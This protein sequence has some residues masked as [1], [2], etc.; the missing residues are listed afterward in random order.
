[1]KLMPRIPNKVVMKPR[2][3]VKTASQGI[4]FGRHKEVDDVTKQIR[5]R[6]IVPKFAKM[7]GRE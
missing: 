4:L 1:M 6:S 3:H 5:K 2:K 7:T